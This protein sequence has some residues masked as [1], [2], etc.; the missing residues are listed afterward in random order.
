MR[1]VGQFRAYID[2]LQLPQTLL[3]DDR[4]LLAIILLV[5]P[6]IYKR[7]PKELRAF[8]PTTKPIY[9]DVFLNNNLGQFES[10]FKE[11]LVCFLWQ[12]YSQSG[13]FEAHLAG[14]AKK[15]GDAAR[16]ETESELFR[17]IRLL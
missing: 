7:A 11:E 6:N 12:K 15:H 3:D 9:R 14:V 17:T 13:A 2:T 5:L 8:L 16:A 1:L 10:F 4:A